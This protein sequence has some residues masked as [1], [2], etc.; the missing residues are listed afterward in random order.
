[1]KTEVR[2]MMNPGGRR[3]DFEPDDCIPRGG[4]GTPVCLIL[5]AFVLFSCAIRHHA[6]FAEGLPEQRNL[7]A[8]EKRLQ[9][10]VAASAHLRM[11]N[12]GQVDYP[13]FQATLLRIHFQAVPSPRYRVLISAAIHGNEPA[14]AET[15]TR[16]V[17]DLSESPQKYK[18]AAIDIVPLINPWGWVHDIRYNQAGIDINRDFASFNS[19]EAVIIRHLLTDSAYDVM[20]DLHEDPTARGFYLYQYGLDDKSACEKI[21]ATIQGMGYPIEQDVSMVILKTE[22]G[23]IEAPMWGL[24]YMRLTGQLSITN[25]CRLNNS[26]F[27]FTVETPA[28]LLWE[29]RLKMQQTAVAILLEQYTGDR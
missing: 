10:A 24:W 11:E 29:D 15:A 6:P 27:V 4:A 2:Y 9:K 12:I 20:V 25:Y 21:V 26:R 1:M 3:T 16:L 17:E 19:Q 7:S 18:N 5:L 28:S 8:F 14:A 22:N 13:V 23:I